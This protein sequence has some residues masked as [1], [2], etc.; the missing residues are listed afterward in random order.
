[1]EVLLQ[2]VSTSH[3]T[4]ALQSRNNR[5]R[6][7]PQ[8]R[9]SHTPAH[10]SQLP[11]GFINLELPDFASAS[12]DLVGGELADVLGWGVNADWMKL[13][14]PVGVDTNLL[15]SEVPYRLVSH[16][17]I[18]NNLAYDSPTGI[19]TPQ[20][21]SFPSPEGNQPLPA[22]RLYRNSEQHIAFSTNSCGYSIP[23]ERSDRQEAYPSRTS[24]INRDMTY[25]S[26]ENYN[27]RTVDAPISPAMPLSYTAD[28]RPLQGVSSVSQ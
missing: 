16:A 7:P 3:W 19:R 8:A 20:P 10:P 24:M 22:D 9:S 15:S 12:S 4:D 18:G 21:P 14:N 6:A 26:A 11:T 2:A 27:W 28:P 5:P 17:S 1:M 23:S 25:V 13:Y